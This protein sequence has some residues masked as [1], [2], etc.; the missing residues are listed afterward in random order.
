ML[1]LAA[2]RYATVRE[3][4]VVVEAVNAIGGAGR[5]FFVAGQNR[6]DMLGPA[7]AAHQLVDPRPVGAMEARACLG[8]QRQ[9]RCC[10][11]GIG[12]EL[13]SRNGFTLFPGFL[14]DHGELL[15]IGTHL[16]F[17]QMRA[18][19]IRQRPDGDKFQAVAGRADLGEHLKAALQ[20]VFF[21]GAERAFEAEG[22]VFNVG[23]T[24][25]RESRARGQC[26]CRDS[27]DC[28]FAKHLSQFLSLTR[29]DRRSA[30]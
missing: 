4:G 12:R 11:G 22:E 21:K 18:A 13:V 26:Q 10:G 17:R 30:T 24:T 1:V 29:P 6:E 9:V 3:G 14:V 19:L 23:A 7:D 28:D 27:A 25:G 8:H 2:I 15:G 5:V 20:L 16:I